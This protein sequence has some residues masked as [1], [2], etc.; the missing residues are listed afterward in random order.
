[1]AENTRKRI[2]DTTNEPYWANQYDK[3]KNVRIRK[4]LYDKLVNDLK[5]PEETISDCIERLLRLTPSHASDEVESEMESEE[6]VTA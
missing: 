5:Y 6:S 1:M 3:N 4:Q 2:S